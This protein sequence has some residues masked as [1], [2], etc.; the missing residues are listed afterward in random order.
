MGRRR[1]TTRTTRTGRAWRRRSSRR[2]GRRR[3]ARP[4]RSSSTTSAR[5][6]ARAAAR[7]TIRCRATATACGCLMAHNV[8]TWLAGNPTGDPAGANRKYLL[9]GD[10]NA[11]F[12]EDPIQAFLG[13]GGYTDL[14]NLLIGPN[15]YS[16]QLRLAVGLSRSRAGQSRRSCRLIKGVAELHIN[17]DE[18]AA[19]EA[20]DSN[21]K[22]ADRAGGLLRRRR[23]R[24]VRSRSDCHRT[25]SARGRPER[26][27]RG[28]SRRSRHHRRELRQAGRSG[29]PP[30]RL[31][32]RRHEL[33]QTTIASGSRFTGCSFGNGG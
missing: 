21:L 3:T 9:I 31:R 11:Y 22:S 30:H 12:G 15:A 1:S 13:A 2:P 23:V 4:S 32:R 26:R 20:L 27:W 8:Q 33:R 7:A 6:A 10:F 29:G 17:A 25:Q 5:R 18:P 24:G 16:L 19:L 14:I 28:E